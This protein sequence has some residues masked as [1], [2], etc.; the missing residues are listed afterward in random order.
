M[1]NC[2]CNTAFVSTEE[3]GIQVTSIKKRIT[4][5]DGGRV[6]F[7]DLMAV[8]TTFIYDLSGS[9]SEISTSTSTCSSDSFDT[10]DFQSF[11]G[12]SKRTSNRSNIGLQMLKAQI[13][14]GA[15]PKSLS[16]HGD[17]TCL[18]FAVLA[19][20][21]D[22]TKE[23]VELGVDVNKANRLGETA[24]GLA[25]ELQRVDIADYLRSKGATVAKVQ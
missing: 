23:L 10:E 25:I 19:N 22:F 4:A 5:S 18:M 15:D 13:H 17:R 11:D 2:V 9:E 8:N 16:T 14:Y 20:D 12:L 3:L 21:Y 24:L 1:G 6:W 7:N